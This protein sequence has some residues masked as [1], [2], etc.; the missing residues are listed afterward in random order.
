MFVLAAQQPLSPPP[1]W[2]HVKL[3]LAR[4]MHAFLLATVCVAFLCDVFSG[5]FTGKLSNWAFLSHKRSK[6][7]DLVQLGRL[8]EASNWTG[9]PKIRLRTNWCF[10]KAAITLYQECWWSFGAF[11]PFLICYNCVIG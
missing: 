4:I 7:I 11:I 2:K 1:L 5:T 6:G 10:R 8:W 9:F 3:E